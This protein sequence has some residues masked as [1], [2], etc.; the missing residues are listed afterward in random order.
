MEIIYFQGYNAAIDFIL[1]S[2]CIGLQ[3]IEPFGKYDLQALV[4]IPP[5]RLK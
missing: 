3:F 2:R 4:L 1:L 5:I